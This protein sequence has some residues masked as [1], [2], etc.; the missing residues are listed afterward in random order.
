MKGGTRAAVLT[1]FLGYAA[2]MI[3]LL[4]FRSRGF[5]TDQSFAEYLRQS[6]NLVPFRTISGYLNAWAGGTMNWEIPFR[7]LLGNI[8][9]FIP[10]GIFLPLLFRPLANFGR[11]LLAL[12]ILLLSI[13]LI[14][15]ITRRGSFDIDDLI[16]NTLGACAGFALYIILNCLPIFK[17][18]IA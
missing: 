3:I 12:S 8:V 9:L 5:A 13:E 18:K 4:F 2:F 10:L 1:G 16:L 17:T 6:V 15:L 11:W 7:N 14:Q